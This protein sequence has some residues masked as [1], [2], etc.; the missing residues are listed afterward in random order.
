MDDEYIRLVTQSLDALGES[1]IHGRF[2]VDFMPFIRYIPRWL[3]GAASAKFAYRWRP[4]VEQ[5]V[6]KP[7]QDIMEQIVSGSDRS[8]LL[9]CS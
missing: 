9:D 3:P 2:W 8:L 7:F 5:M 1:R 4:V 6:N